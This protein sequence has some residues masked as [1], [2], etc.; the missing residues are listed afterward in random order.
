[1]KEM[2]S[3]THRIISGLIILLGILHCIFTA[4]NY[5]QFTLNAMWFFGTGIAIILAG[6]LN[7][8][9]IR[10]SGTDR[11]V[12]FLCLTTNLAFAIL[13]TVALLLL[14]QPQ[15]LVGMVL[16]A[17]AAGLVAVKSRRRLAGTS[18]L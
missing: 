17:V 4:W 5:D 15:V 10:S 3:L 11:V 8:T 7:V 9:V 6:F 13:F 14:S 2:L 18:T 12:N 16:F 1:V